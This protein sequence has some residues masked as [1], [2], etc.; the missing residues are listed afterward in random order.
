MRY[1]SLIF[2]IVLI[3]PAVVEAGGDTLTL[4]EA[5]DAALADDHQLK[6]ARYDWSAK[7]AETAINRSQYF[8]RIF[9]EEGFVSTNSPT[10]AFML[11][12]D[13]GRFSLNGDL[14]HPKVGSDFRT[15]FSLEQPLLN[16]AI[17]PGVD[18]AEAAGRGQGFALERQRQ[19]TAFRV[20]T[21]YLAVQQAKGHAVA[22]EAAVND[23]KEHLRVAVVRRE[24]GTGLKADE[25]RARTFLSERELEDITAKNDLRLAQL[26]L[27]RAVGRTTGS[28]TDISEDIPVIDSR[29]TWEE[30]FRL[31]M[32]NRQELRE[33]VTEIERA[34]AGVRAARSG[35]LPTVYGSAS[36]QMNDRDIP[37][38][39]DNDSWAV[40]ALLRWELFDGMQRRYRVE[41][42]R[43][44]RSAASELFEHRRADVALEVEEK[45][46]RREEAEQRLKVAR[47]ALL[48]AEEAL[49]LVSK[50]FQNSLATI[51]ETLDAQTALNG[52]RVRLID[53]EIAAAQASAGLWHAAGIFMREVGR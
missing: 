51:S 43:S 50:R 4:R 30:L 3:I 45:F 53:A 37:F 31:A 34:D 40:G 41:Q 35:Y 20:M 32:E 25:L 5:I 17:R 48:D 6:A 46:L 11:K 19:D 12:L 2:G 29:H 33:S 42:T 38:G 9:L 28:L 36:Y 21:A 47:H 26:K 52:S 44:I 49:R 1:L 39:R 14:N 23:A 24:S 13:E 8:P 7:K 22:S 18:A 15:T 10:K 16:F 27:A